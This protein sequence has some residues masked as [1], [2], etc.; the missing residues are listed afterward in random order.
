MVEQGDY[1][2]KFLV[3]KCGHERRLHNKNT[4]TG[5]YTYCSEVYNKKNK[6][7]CKKFE[8]QHLSKEIKMLRESNETT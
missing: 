7:P 1:D 4:S 6:C 2:S 3:C 8:V 5:H